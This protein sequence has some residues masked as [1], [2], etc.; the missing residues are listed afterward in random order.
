MVKG[1]RRGVL[2]SAQT[3]HLGRLPGGCCAQLG[4]AR[5]WKTAAVQMH[6]STSANNGSRSVCVEVARQ[7]AQKSTRQGGWEVL[8]DI[9]FI[10]PPWKVSQVAQCG[11]LAPMFLTC[12]FQ[13]LRCR[14]KS[15]RAVTVS[16]S[17]TAL[18]IA[19]WREMW[20][21]CRIFP[22]RLHHERRFL[23][24]ERRCLLRTAFP[25]CPWFLSLSLSSSFSLS[26]TLP[27]FLSLVGCSRVLACLW[28]AVLS[29]QPLPLAALPR[30][31]RCNGSPSA[32]PRRR[33]FHQR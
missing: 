1:S 7:P 24:Q 13:Y 31:C 3:R 17:T 5:G 18:L 19:Y 16:S 27:L 6:T 32:W 15:L 30:G 20:A 26:V 23:R 9:G 21:S 28:A 22:R 10:D 4:V 8:Q 14:T 25:L 29:Q 2:C 12:R 33:G 11:P